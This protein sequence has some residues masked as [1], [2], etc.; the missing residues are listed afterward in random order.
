MII[1]IILSSRCLCMYTIVCL[2]ATLKKQQ[3]VSMHSC[4]HPHIGPLGD[5]VVIGK[6]ASKRMQEWGGTDTGGEI[7]FG[8]EGPFEDDDEDEVPSATPRVANTTNS[9]SRSPSV[10]RVSWCLLVH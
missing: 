5:L 10:R 4:C 1:K 6:H 3:N 2:I 9:P 8:D 7:V